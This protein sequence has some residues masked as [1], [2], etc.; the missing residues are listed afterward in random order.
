MT[1]LGVALFHLYT[2]QVAVSGLA[3]ILVYKLAFTKVV[4]A[5]GLAAFHVGRHLQHEWVI[6]ANLLCLLLGFALL[7][8]HFE[9]TKIPARL[10]RWLPHGWRG[11]FVLL[12]L[13]FLL[14]SFLDNIAAAMIGAT[15][16]RVVFKGKVHVGF[17][18]AV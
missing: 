18:A 8:N 16:A 15:V 10:P 3:S 12:V 7:S 5:H 17:L 13:V 4:T 9:E 2:L 6:L 14:S 1:L 11:G